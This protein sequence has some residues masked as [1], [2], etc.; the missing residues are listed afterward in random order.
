MSPEKLLILKN[1]V[2]DHSYK[3]V[4]GER[5]ISSADVKA[6]QYVVQALRD[7][8]FEAAAVEAGAT[9][10]SLEVWEKALKSIG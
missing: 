6:L 9:D 3:A 5:L 4:N 10:L 7:N 2:V 8:N 1:A